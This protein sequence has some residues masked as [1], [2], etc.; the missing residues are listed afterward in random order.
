M[1]EDR[2]SQLNPIAPNFH[3][4]DHEPARS[5][6]SRLSAETT[7]GIPPTLNHYRTCLMGEPRPRTKLLRHFQSSNSHMNNMPDMPK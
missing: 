6:D 7:D 3:P 2:S 4:R 1:R 5:Q